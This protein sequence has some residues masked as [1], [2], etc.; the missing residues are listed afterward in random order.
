MSHN[1]NLFIESVAFFGRVFVSRNC[2]LFHWLVFLFW[3]NSGGDDRRNVCR[4]AAICHRA[5]RGTTPP[6]GSPQDQFSLRGLSSLLQQHIRHNCFAS[7]SSLLSS[8]SLSPSPPPQP[9][10]STHPSHLHPA[11]DYPVSI[12]NDL[13]TLFP[14]SSATSDVEPW[15]TILFQKT[16][17]RLKIRLFNHTIQDKM[18]LFEEILIFSSKLG[19]IPKQAKLGGFL[20]KEEGTRLTN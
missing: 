18:L 15:V 14:A 13:D 11:P 16:Q 8:T 9:P 10:A 3:A 5:L 12:R 6:D 19:T 20:R 17:N 7:R 4:E 2:L 1:V